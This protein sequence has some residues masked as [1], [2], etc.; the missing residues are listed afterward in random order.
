MNE[1]MNKYIFK[2]KIYP[3]N[4]YLPFNRI[5]YILM[6]NLKKLWVTVFPRNL[7]YVIPRLLNSLPLFS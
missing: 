7:K 5:V 6:G 4:I 3:Y 2:I 1:R